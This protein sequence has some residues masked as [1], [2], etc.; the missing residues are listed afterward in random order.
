MTAHYFLECLLSVT[1]IN[2]FINRLRNMLI[3]VMKKWKYYIESTT[4][5]TELV[6]DHSLIFYLQEWICV[7]KYTS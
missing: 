7:L 6:W 5:T 3:P 4:F 1:Y 2:R